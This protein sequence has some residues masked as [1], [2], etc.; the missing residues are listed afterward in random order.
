MPHEP[1]PVAFIVGSDRVRLGA[2]QMV[3]DAAAR[4][5]WPVREFSQVPVY[6]E[7]RKYFVFAERKAVPPFVARYELHPWPDNLHDQSGRTVFYDEGY[8]AERDEMAKRRRRFDRLHFLLFPFY[9]LLGL[10]WSGFKNRVLQPMGF[11]PRSITWASVILMF[12]LCLVEGIFVGWLQG[13]LLLWWFA[14]GR[15]RVLDQVLVWLL[16]LDSILRC[17]QLL[18]WD[19]QEHLGFC[20][21]LWPRKRKR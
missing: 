12:N 8:V 16:A 2:G 19:V 17:H 11:E 15:W 18:K 6:F 3:V 20:E 13:G 4:M 21:W 1:S 10:C 9:P 5:D 14:D 7:G